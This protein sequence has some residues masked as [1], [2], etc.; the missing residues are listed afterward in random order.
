MKTVETKL[1]AGWILEIKM[2]D[3]GTYTVVQEIKEADPSSKFLVLIE[4]S[5][6]S[7]DD[8]FMRHEPTHK[9]EQEFK[10]LLTKV[11]K[12][13]V[14]DFYKP[15]GDLTFT[16]TCANV[17]WGPGRTPATGRA[18]DW[19][20]NVAKKYMPQKASRLGTKDEYIA[21][22]GVLIKTLIYEGWAVSDAWYA[23]CVDSKRLGHYLNS[24]D[25]KKDYE[26]T[27]SREICGLCDL[28]NTYKILAWD[29]EA[30]GFWLASGFYFCNSTREPLSCLYF[31][32]KCIVILDFS[33]GWLVVPA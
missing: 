20:E 18:Y 13:G 33:T 32:C 21:F 17:C 16:K 31:Y 29:E 2:Q 25:A 15:K 10:E 7:L 5:K 11:I 12:K 9:R 27:G 6:L 1:P 23:V 19:W 28:A 30:G 3:D 14:K 8:E 4:A 22:L 26:P 24:E